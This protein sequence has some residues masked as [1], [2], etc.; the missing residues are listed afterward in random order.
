MTYSL[1][2]LEALCKQKNVS[3]TQARRIILRVIAE[4]TDH[5]DVETLHAR[6]SVADK[7]I[8]VSTVYRTVRVLTEAGILT[9]HI[10]NDNRTRYET[11]G[12][13]HHDHLIN[14]TTG[15]VIEFFDAEIEALQEKIAQ[16]LGYT[17]LDH[18]LELYAKPLEK[19]QG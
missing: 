18:R 13:D 15:E 3:L 8:S 9:G 6:V 7:R 17:L 19:K 11:M 16:K 5:P 2:D 12:R 4:S 14:V 10:F 1:P